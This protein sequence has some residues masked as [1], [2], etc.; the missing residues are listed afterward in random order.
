MTNQSDKQASI[1]AITGTTGTYEGDWHALFTARGIAAG[2]FN[3]RLLGWIN[4]K[5]AASYTE[6]NS[7]M[8]ALAAANSYTNWN[9]MGAFDAS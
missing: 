2:T 8:A 3:Q 9:S 5:L 1:R 4:S 6:L 7:A